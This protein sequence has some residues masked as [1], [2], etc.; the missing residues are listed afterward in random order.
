MLLSF[1]HTR[2]LALAA[3]L[4]L[5]TAGCKE[6]VSAPTPVPRD[7]PPGTVSP[8]P[9]DGTENPPQQGQEP[10]VAEPPSSTP[11][12]GAAAS[13]N[14]DIRVQVV[15]KKG[16]DQVIAR[17]KGKVVLVDGWATWCVPCR[18][19]FP[20]TVHLFKEYHDD[21]LDVISLSFDA[22]E[23]GQ[24]PRQV[25]DFLTSQGA[26]FENL[27]SAEAITDS[28]AQAFDIDGGALPHFKLYN[29]DG[30]LIRAFASG[31]PDKIFTHDDVERAVREALGV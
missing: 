27:I 30:K 9:T 15:D 28:G 1:R 4:L 24:V 13:A 16:Y 25:I 23:D 10:P 14:G 6:D 31:D 20:K 3:G 12:S 22:V 18:K 17:H 29:R 26:T 19:E 7:V 8:V 21:G 5:W 11:G 2:S